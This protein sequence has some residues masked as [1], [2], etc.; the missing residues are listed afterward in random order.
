MAKFPD[1]PDFPFL[2]VIEKIH[3]V[4]EFSGFLIFAPRRVGGGY[5][6][7]PVGVFLSLRRALFPLLRLLVGNP[8]AARLRLVFLAL[9]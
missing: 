2:Y 1:I 8:M 7:A 5:F 4:R 6:D 3:I 9:S